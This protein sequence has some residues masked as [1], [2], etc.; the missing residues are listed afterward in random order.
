MEVTAPV[1]PNVGKAESR[2]R[3]FTRMNPSEFYGSKV[4][5]DPQEFIDEVYKVLIIMGLTLVEK[6]ELTA[7]QLKEMVGKECRTAM[8]INDIGICHLMVHAQQIKEDKLKERSLKTKRAKTD[9]GNFTHVGKMD[10]VVLGFN[11]GFPIKVSP[12]CGKKH[13][14]NCLAGTDGC[15]SCD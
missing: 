2:V 13:E 15:F 4:E 11:K 10:M 5:V 1:N 6:M 14:G 9:D 12:I 8:L 7:Y 3:G